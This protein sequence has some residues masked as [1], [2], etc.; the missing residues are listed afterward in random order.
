MPRAAQTETYA[1]PAPVDPDAA[2]TCAATDDITHLL[3]PPIPDK[4]AAPVLADTYTALSHMT[5]Y[6]TPA[7]VDFYAVI[8]YAARSSAGTNATPAPRHLHILSPSQR[9]LQ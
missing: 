3:E 1:A 7:F 2:A 5:D 6:V 4:F 9:P 8:D